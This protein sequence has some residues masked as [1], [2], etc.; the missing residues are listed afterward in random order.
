MDKLIIFSSHRT[1]ESG[2]VGTYLRFLIE[3]C[4]KKESDFEL[5]LGLDSF[6]LIKLKVLKLIDLLI[7]GK[8]DSEIIYLTRYI[9]TLKSVLLSK[10]KS[11]DLS[12]YS[13]III[14]CHEKHTSIASQLIKNIFGNKIEIKI[15]QTLHAPFTDGFKM[16]NDNNH[17]LINFAEILD[18][19]STIKI[20]KLIGVDNLQS[21]IANSLVRFNPNKISVINNAVDTNYLDSLPNINPIKET[22]GIDNYFI[23]ARHL[24][25]KNGVIYGVKAFNLFLKKGYVNYK[26]IIMGS[27]PEKNNLLNYI[28]EQ[29][30]SDY[31]ILI[32]RKEYFDSVQII[33]N[34]Y[35]S[36]IP[37][38]PIG[39]YIEATS[40]T[41]LESMYLGVPVL[42][43]NIGGLAQVIENKFNGLLNEPTNIEAMLYNMIE[44]V[45]N[46]ELRNIIIENARKT[47]TSDY[48]TESWFSKIESV[49]Y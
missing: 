45:E 15:I 12:K 22:L 35:A 46:Q 42:A 23:I 25:V 34:A 16:T 3:Q 11:I 17:S 41:M 1:L 5:I 14:H 20:D 48:S 19:G 28:K 30:I 38:I 32:G 6:T 27:G 21:E 40:L 24:G 2:G 39:K 9:I 29:Q 49:Y 8:N 7:H 44:I 47:I 4:K 37:S 26:L 33:K 36:I 10:L 43:S 31:V 18:I 13:R